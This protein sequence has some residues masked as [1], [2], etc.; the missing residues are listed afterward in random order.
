MLGKSCRGILQPLMFDLLCRVLCKVD[1]DHPFVTFKNLMLEQPITIIPV[2]YLAVISVLS[3]ALCIFERPTD[4]E[5]LDLRNG[6]WVIFVTMTTVGYGDLYPATDLGRTICVFACGFAILILMLL[7]IGMN[8]Y[9]APDSKEF[10]VFHILKYKRWK[11]NMHQKAAVVIQ[12]FW[13]CARMID[14]P[15]QPLLWQ[16]SYVADTKL[17]FDVRT[18]R[19]LRRDEPMEQRDIGTLLWE[20]YQNVNV[21]QTKLENINDSINAQTGQDNRSDS[22]I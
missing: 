8:S 4:A 19:R 17:C 16:N 22:R 15:N 3:Y 20:V 2:L 12:S 6:I 7:I 1:L 13:R 18:F 9:M 5:F 21:L 14:R 10:K 11:R